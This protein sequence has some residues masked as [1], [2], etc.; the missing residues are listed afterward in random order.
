[1][2]EKAGIERDVVTV[3]MNRRLDVWAKE[4]FDDDGPSDKDV[5]AYLAPRGLF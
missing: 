4:R 5:A 1:L 2:R 3:G